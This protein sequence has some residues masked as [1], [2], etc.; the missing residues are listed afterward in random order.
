MVNK[1]KTMGIIN[2][3]EN[4]FFNWYNCKESLQA[5]INMARQDVDIL[6]IGAESTK[7]GSKPVDSKT[8]L[9]KILPLIQAIKDNIEH[10][11][12]ISVDT[13]EPEVMRASLEAGAKIINDVRSFSYCDAIEIAAKYDAIVCL[14]HMQGTPETM[15]EN[16]QYDSGV[17]KEIRHW[18]KQ[19]YERC[20]NA[21][22]NKNNIYLDPGFGFGKTREHNWQL[23]GNI[24]L[25]TKDYQICI[26]VSRKSMFKDIL[27]CSLPTKRGMVSNI[28][29]SI[30]ASKGVKIIRT[31]CINSTKQAISAAGLL[32]SGGT[33]VWN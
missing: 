25:F 14:T 28:A 29:E 24:E 5:A 7:P 3:S 27:G 12:L 17:V 31:H 22:I 11:P 32:L 16:P 20:T 13:S 19:Q 23:L 8:Q 21:G 4:S 6:D 9:K 26:G 2:L 10:P 15:Q 30:A 33:D 1:P 18:C